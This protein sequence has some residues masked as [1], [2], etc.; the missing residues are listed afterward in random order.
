[1]PDPTLSSNSPD[2]K[3]NPLET[4]NPKS[5]D[6]LFEEDPEKLT[7]GDL[8]RIVARLR[9]GRKNFAAAEQAGKKPKAQTKTGVPIEFD[10]LFK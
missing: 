6:L 3:D 10:D 7:D 2:L 8:D 1:M 9:E 5:L 4:V